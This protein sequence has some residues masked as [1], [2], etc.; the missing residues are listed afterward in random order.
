MSTLLTSSPTIP[1]LADLLDRLGGIAPQRVR[2]YPAPGTATEPDVVA[3]HGRE[4]RLCELIDGVLVEKP[5]GYRESIL[6]IA[7]AAAVRAFVKP[8]DL[9]VVS[10]AD[11][12]IRLLPGLVR[13]P[14]VAFISRDRLP[15]G[16]VPHEAVLPMAPDLAVEV[17][18]D[19]NTIAEMTR[20]REEYFSAGVRLM[21][22]FDID[23]RNVTVYAGVDRSKIVTGDQI[24]EGGDVLPGFALPLGELFAEVA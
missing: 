12:M 11:G 14:D 18:S 3:V 2:F 13:I 9:G 10:G 19:S 8:R 23:A 20:K 7:I 5:M 21:W 4:K 6:A 22:V 17:L 16:R 24:L 1:T 15:S